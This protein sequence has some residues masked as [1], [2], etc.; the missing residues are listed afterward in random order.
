MLFS[1]KGPDSAFCHFSGKIV[2]RVTTSITI[3][4][5]PNI[6]MLLQFV[7]LNHTTK[8]NLIISICF[9]KLALY[10]NKHLIK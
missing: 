8:I 3:A 1:S 10:N 2:G 7:L 9:S 6:Q 5:I 4:G